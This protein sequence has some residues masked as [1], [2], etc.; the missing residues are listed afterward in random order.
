[1]AR[2]EPD[3]LTKISVRIP[4]GSEEPVME[5]LAEFFGQPASVYADAQTRATTA[6]VYLDKS[7][8]WSANRRSALRIRFRELERLGFRLGNVRISSSTIRRQDWAESWKRH[9]KAIQIGQKLLIRPSWIQRRPARGQRVVVL[10]PGLSFGT[11]QHATTRF[12]LEQLVAARKP[13]QAQSLLDIGTGSGILA[14]AAVK[15]GYRPVA[16]FDF[17][18]EA[19]RIAGQNARRN[20]VIPPLRIRCQDLGRLPEQPDR[21]FDVVCANLISD[22]ILRERDRILARV[23]TGGRL[24]LAGILTREFGE[25]RDALEQVGWEM[26]GRRVEREWTS[27]TFAKQGVGS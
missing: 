10:D 13:G 1:V 23:K 26:I 21:R 8:D 2:F 15:A 3:V 14:I 12:C 16:A 7:R 11:G 4:P 9:F 25:I 22:L 20:R 5:L 18:P 19:V 24:I 17:D 27:G 6:S